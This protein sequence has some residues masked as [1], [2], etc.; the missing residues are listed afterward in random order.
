M[1]RGRYGHW[2]LLHQ[3]LTDTRLDLDVRAAGALLLLF[4]QHLARIAVLPTTALTA[5]DGTTFLPL[6]RTPR[7]SGSVIPAGAWETPT[8][9][10]TQ[11]SLPGRAGLWETETSVEDRWSNVMSSG[12]Q[13]DRLKWDEIPS[14]KGS[15][16]VC[17]RIHSEV[18]TAN[19]EPVEVAVGIADQ[20]VM[21]DGTPDTNV[22]GRGAEAGQPTTPPADRPSVTT[23]ATPP[24][25]PRPLPPPGPPRHPRNRLPGHVRTDP[26]HPIRHHP[27]PPQG[28]LIMRAPTALLVTAAFAALLTTGTA[29]AADTTETAGG[30]SFTHPHR[31]ECEAG[32]DG[33]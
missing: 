22:F 31:R 29:H 28:S 32:S 7:F 4:G 27:Q 10:N 2:N 6:G 20:A 16:E 13:S 26:G 12:V 3:C 30:Y 14:G 23:A 19:A 33:R 11:L 5:G 25:R 1:R 24:R 17:A 8:S 18:Q 9:V 15:T 21:P